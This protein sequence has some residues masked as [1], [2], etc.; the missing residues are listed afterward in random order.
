MDAFLPDADDTL[1]ELNL[2]LAAARELMQDKDL[3]EGVTELL[4]TSTATLKQ[5]E[6]VAMRVDGL[7]LDNRAIVSQAMRSAADTMEEIHR[8]TRMVTELIGDPIWR[9][10]AQALLAQLNSTGKQAES[11]IASLNEFVNDPEL[12]EPLRRTMENVDLITESG[13]RIASNTEEMTRNGIVISEKAIELADRANEIAA[14]AKT[15][16]RRIQDFFERVPTGVSLQP[17]YE[18]DLL[19]DTGTNRW[20]TDVGVQIPTGEGVVHLGVFDA[21]ESN[22]LTLQLARPFSASAEYR[23]GIYAS[24]PGVGVDYRVAPRASLR[25]DLFD[26][27]NPRLDLRFRYDFNR[28]YVGWLGVNRIFND[29]AITLGI[30]VRR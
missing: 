2:T 16:V 12:R 5:F 1:R 18:M 14:E 13:T 27:N 26:I 11:L 28:E 20:R 7:L 6:L 30:G 25:G 4:A 24:K 23:Y 19:R 15:V 8:G 10:E 3:K 21:F 22:K 9:D 29:N 17:T